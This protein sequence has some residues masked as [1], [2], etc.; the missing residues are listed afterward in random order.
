MT[1]KLT[2]LVKLCRPVNFIITFI[3][4]IVASIICSQGTLPNQKIFLAAFVAAIV[5]A[6]GNIYNDITDIEIDKINRP[7]RPLPSG[8][9]KSNEAYI[10]YFFYTAIAVGCSF[11]L[12]SIASIIVLFSILLLII[13]SKILKRIPIL[14]NFTIAL[15]AGLVFIFGGVVVDNPAAAIIPAVFAFLINL[16]R[17]I[18]KDMEDIDGDKKVGIKTFPIAFG[19]QKSKYLILI[20]S[21][22]LILF[23][24]YPFI[25]KIY[26]I[27]YF[28][29][30]MVFVNSL[31]IYCLKILFQDQSVKNL[32]KVSNLL[33]ISMVIGLFAIYLGV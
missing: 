6:S 4:V 10:L 32:R 30:V 31:I 23:T 19:Y 25:T 18:V 9:I 17:E 8:K 16:I 12:D 7:D 11:F 33:K 5:L 29:I 21:F 24:L 3:S 26:K 14:G 22:I 27:E 2:T 20:L 28:V 1:E 13:Y 15:L